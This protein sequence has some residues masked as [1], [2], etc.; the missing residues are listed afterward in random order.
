MQRKTLISL[1]FFVTT[2]VAC[3]TLLAQEVKVQH[4]PGTDFAK[5]HTYKWVTIEGASHPNQIQDAEIKQ[6]VD[7][8]L[9][10]KGLTKANS[11]TADLNVGY[12][13]AVDQQKQ[14][15]TMGG[16][17]RFGGMETVTSSTIDVGTLVIDMYD[18]AGKQLVWSGAA[19]KTV[20][21]G[22]DQEK[23]EKSLDKSMKKLFK[24]FPPKG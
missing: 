20:D 16:G 3:N 21:S 5:F 18:Q 8:E 19:T 9:T 22:K 11:E 23:T 4:M 1:A 14:W 6:A 24:D 13:V 17:W 10:A 7:A 2:F 15:N 12:Q